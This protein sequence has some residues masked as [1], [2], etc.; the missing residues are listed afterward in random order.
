MGDYSDGMIGGGN[1]RDLLHRRSSP[2]GGAS[3]PSSYKLLEEQYSC[4]ITRYSA[5][6]MMIDFIYA[7]SAGDVAKLLAENEIPFNYETQ[8]IFLTETDL[9]KLLSEVDDLW[10]C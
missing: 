2:L 9:Q 1:K 5:S 10:G 7:S 6:Q 8:E 3:T 4:T